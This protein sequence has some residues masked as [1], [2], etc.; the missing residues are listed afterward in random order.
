M[1]PLGLRRPSAARLAAVLV[2]CGCIAPGSA[3]GAAGGG[4]A[5]TST[6]AC[7]SAAANCACTPAPTPAAA[8]V[9]YCFIPDTISPEAQAVLRAT[10]VGAGLDISTPEKVKA[11]RE[12][13]VQGRVQITERVLQTLFESAVDGTLGGVPSVLGLPRG[14]GG[15]RGQ[16]HG[17]VLMYLH[18]GGYVLGS[19]RTQ[20]ATA[21]QVAKPLGL[22][23]QGVDFRVAPEHAYPAALDDAVAAYRALLASH[24]PKDIALLGDSA[25][26][27]L[28]LALL[29][30]LKREGLPQPA[31]AVLCSPW[32]ELTKQGDT[33]TTL[34]GV[35]PIL[36]YEKKLYASA[37]AYVGGDE[38]KLTDPLVS[39][40]RADFTIASAG[41]LPP[42]L[43]QVGLRDTFLSNAARLYR[44]LVKAGQPA[45]F[46]PWEGMWHVFQAWLDVPEA[47]EAT[48]EAA[49]FLA[50]HMAR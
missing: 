42:I 32:V 31:A 6:A 21:G 20:W 33:Q 1:A 13:F 28:A 24:P 37:L 46:S 47:R 45:K 26:G 29:L 48:A 22:Q 25:G 43:I 39:P 41:Q 15:G 50:A 38:S 4:A 35:D 49:A 23:V 27:G 3:G 5:P 17:K 7:P 10:A 34:T 19:A 36:Q 30:R 12:A 11:T 8:A 44:K 2:A 40:L 16:L 18:G 9:P 14:Y